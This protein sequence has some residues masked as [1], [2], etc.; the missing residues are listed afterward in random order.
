MPSAVNSRRNVISTRI[1][2]AT[3]SASTSV[4]STGS[5]CA[6]VEVDDREDD[7]RALR[8]GELVD[9]ERRDGA[10]LVGK[11]ARRARR[12]RTS[13]RSM[14]PAALDD[15]R[16]GSGRRGGSTGSSPRHDEVAAVGDRR[17]GHRPARRPAGDGA[18]D[19][20]ASVVFKTIA[21]APSERTSSTI[22]LSRRRR[23]RARGRAAA[24]AA[25]HRGCRPS[26]RGDRRSCPRQRRTPSRLRR[27]RA[28]AARRRREHRRRPD[29]CRRTRARSSAPRPR[30]GTYFVSPNRSSHSLRADVA[31]HSPAVDEL[32]GHTGVRNELRQQ[33]SVLVVAP[34]HRGGGIATRGLVGGSRPAGS[35]VTGDSK[36][37]ACGF[38]PAARSARDRGAHRA[39]RV[40]R[41][42][43]TVEPQR[44]MDGGC[45][46]LVEV[47][48]AR[49]REPQ[50]VRRTGAP[51]QSGATRPRPP[52]SCESSSYD[53]TARVPLP[54][55]VPASGAIWVRSSRPMRHVHA[56]AENP[57]H[58]P[59]DTPESDDPS[60]TV[61]CESQEAV[62]DL[63]FSRG[64]RPAY[65]PPRT[66]LR[67]YQ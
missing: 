67:R 56:P 5:R 15:G 4:S 20:I 55:P 1:P 28:R 9:R 51:T 48:G 21:S 37:R 49:R 60:E 3:S 64:T 44:G 6:V 31:G 33:R 22:G 2:I 61:A 23:A 62:G 10:A 66:E 19:A 58:G 29:R 46:G 32:L 38:Q 43:R 57:A 50:R 34:Q 53:A 65:D 63:C 25:R 7:R 26:R 59:K 42:C 41:R 36:R 16:A 45:V 14:R 52:S 39:H 13:S 24:A 12:A 18:Y 11:H 47:G 40:V 27:T 35:H 30:A 17:T 8:V 54:P